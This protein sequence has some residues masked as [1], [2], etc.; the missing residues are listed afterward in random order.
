MTDIYSKLSEERKQLQAEGL[1]PPWF[2][3]AGWQLFKGKYS[4][5]NETPRNH[6]ERIART[7]AKHYPDS[8]LAESKFFHLLWTGWL[9]PSTPILAN[10][11][12]DRGLPVSCSGSSID[13][14]IDG[15]Y[16][17]RLETALLTKYGF[18]TSAYLGDIRPRGSIIS[19]GGK[20]SGVVP[21]FKGFVQDMRDVAQG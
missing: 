13:D 14:S 19:T 9:S 5:G 16:S 10:M 2:T 1:L 21:V 17:A 4:Y 12:L 6:Y 18:G 3:T 20:A 8:A 11:G 7:A 15:F